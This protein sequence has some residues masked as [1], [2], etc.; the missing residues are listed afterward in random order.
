MWVCGY[1]GSHGTEL[2]YLRTANR[3]AALPEE[4]NWYIGFRCAADDYGPQASHRIV[5]KT[6]SLADT[7][8]ASKRDEPTSWPNWSAD[9]V[10]PLV[11]RYV[12]IAMPAGNIHLPFDQ[13]NHEP[14]IT[15]CRSKDRLLVTWLFF[16]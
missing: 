8:S 5:P 3:A 13:H 4:R 7:S 1:A 14:A 9:P 12:N 16:L 6:P 10:S 11:R 15:Y 2:Y